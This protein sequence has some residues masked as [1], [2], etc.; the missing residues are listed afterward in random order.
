MADNEP[1]PNARNA[2]VFTAEAY[3]VDGALDA[4]PNG[5]NAS[6][7]S[8]SARAYRRLE[9]TLAAER[10][11]SKIAA[12]EFEEAEVKRK[13]LL[14]LLDERG[15]KLASLEANEKLA[16]TG[17]VAEVRLLKK[18]HKADTKSEKDA[19]KKA[20]AILTAKIKDLQ[21][22]KKSATK[23]FDK[24]KKTND[25]LMVTH[26]DLKTSKSKL[27]AEHVAVLN[28]K[29]DLSKTVKS[30]AS[31][32]KSLSSKVD[33]QQESKQQ[34]TKDLASMRLKT[35]ELA[36]EETR[37]RIA[38]PTLAKIPKTA[39]VAMGLDAKKELAT[40]NALL[41]KQQKDCDEQRNASKKALKKK[42]LQTNLGFA[43]GML[44]STSNLN[45]GMWSHSSVAEVS[46]FALSI[47]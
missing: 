29:A 46:S 41:K 19:V 42:E 25:A 30:Q 44:Q 2:A 36:L 22:D 14:E 40:H 47:I 20:T 13:K 38:N 6:T 23:V 15:L 32:I 7:S 3:A 1:P 43:A 27:S 9:Q 35:K 31:K 24:L 26:K 18:L 28:V 12:Q 5:N 39:S 17:S 10:K 34:H 45:G 37:E 16:K 8:H 33:N 11:K 21:A 4:N